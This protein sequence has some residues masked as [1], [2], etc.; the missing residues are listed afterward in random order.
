MEKELC[1]KVVEVRRRSDRVMM[2]VF[3]LEEEVL[4]II[5]VYAHRVAERLQKKSIFMMI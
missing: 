3:V 2:V 4:R 1:E 5:Y